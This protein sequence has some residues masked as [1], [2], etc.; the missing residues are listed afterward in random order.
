MTVTILPPHADRFRLHPV[1]SRLATMF[2]FALLTVSCA[3][4]SFALACATPFAAFAVVAAAMLPM[5]PALLVVTGAW[6]VN[7]TIGFGVLHYPIDGSTIAWGFVIGA[8]ALL[9]TAAASTVL[10]LLPQGRTPLM[11]AIALV[12]AY[13]A[14]ELALLAA[15][16][17]LGGEGAFTA[18]I[19]TRIGLTSAVWLAGLVAACEIVR[20]VDPFGRKGAMS[21]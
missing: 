18:A 7:Q 13:A 9:S 4:A 17:F 19:V 1:T 8:A 15:T 10:R 2:C 6:L 21:A 5:R 3:L 12:A 14:Y 11:L 20:L 16:P